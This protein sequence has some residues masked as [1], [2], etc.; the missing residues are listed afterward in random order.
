LRANSGASG[1]SSDSEKSGPRSRNRR[2][3]VATRILILASPSLVLFGIFLGSILFGFQLSFFKF[4]SQRLYI[5]T[6]TL[7]N[8][9]AILSGSLYLKGAITTLE[10]SALVTV[11]AVVLG[12][13]AGYLVARTESNSLR[14]LLITSLFIS[15]FVS[16]VVK[17]YGWIVILSSNGLINEAI[18]S[19]GLAKSPIPLLFS[20]N[21]V[22]ITLIQASI[23]LMAFFIYSVVSNINRSMEEAAQSLGASGVRTFFMITLP[24]S[25][26]GLAG[27][28]LL[29][30][31]IAST[32]FI[33][34]ILIGGGRLITLSVLI[35][36]RFVEIL[37]WPLGSAIAFVLLAITLV[38]VFVYLRLLR[39]A[40]LPEG[41]V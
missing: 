28:S 23:P 2:R 10:L 8:Y 16:S 38:I 5:P 4:S 41:Y 36:T 27:A 33:E 17:L 25:L 13:P 31:S 29:I 21:G 35:Y 26:P 7:E 14:L 32:V 22:V 34:P 12:Y 9:E 39:Y 11:G 24:L 20:F 3:R 1:S 40:G 30:F 19:L 6:L 15:L 37:D 18:L